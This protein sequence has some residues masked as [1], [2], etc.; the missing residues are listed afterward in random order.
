M[1]NDRKRDFGVDFGSGFGSVA[2]ATTPKMIARVLADALRSKTNGAR[3]SE[4]G[5]AGRLEGRPDTGR[6]QK[7]QKGQKGRKGEETCAIL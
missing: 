4:S 7:G 5:P 6:R 3:S 1:P 2:T